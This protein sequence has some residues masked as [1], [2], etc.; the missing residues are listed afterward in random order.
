M[1]DAIHSLIDSISGFLII[2]SEKIAASSKFSVHR[3]K[4]ER[5]TTIIIALIIIA[6]GIH[7]F[8]ESIEKIIE[9]ESIDYSIWTIVILIISIIIKYLLAYY[10]KRTGKNLKSGVLI[11]SSAETMNDTWI[12]IA[13]FLSVIIY[14]LFQIN[15]EA[16]ISILISIIIVKV[17]L[18]FVFPH[19]SRHHHHALET[20]PDHDHCKKK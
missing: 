14:M 15:T 6:T 9:P 5:T 12:S 10:L 3:V 18:E 1:S 4:I 11:A 16:Y 2:I 19:I 8:I 13:V 17:G 20:D 7:I